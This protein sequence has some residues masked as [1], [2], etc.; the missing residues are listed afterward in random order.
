MP[1]LVN[2]TGIAILSAVTFAWVNIV[3][4]HLL[5]KR[6]PG[7]RAFMLSLGIIH[8]IYGLLL[9]YLFPLPEGLGALLVL[10]AVVSGALRTVAATIMIYC[11]KKEE[12]SRVIPVV[13]TY[14]IFVA[15]IA[16]LFLGE[17]LGYLQWLA[18]IIVVVGAVILSIR[19][20]PFGSTVW[21]GRSFLL[22]FGSS[23]FFALSDVTSKY[24]LAYISSWNMFSL[25]AFCISGSFLLVS[26][27]PQVLRQLSNLER[28]NWTLALIA[29]NETLAP[30]AS[31][32][33]FLALQSGPVS[34]VSTIVSSRPIF[35]VIFALI[36]SRFLP[37]FL[38][39]Q[40]GKGML[41][42]RLMATVMIVGG[43]AIIY[44]S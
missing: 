40:P 1:I 8:L 4:G 39:W 12:V 10:V 41:A 3:D 9:F 37:G 31:I 6:L 43:I 30:V 33:L 32:L 20:S 27:R 22:L 34:L 16:V 38:V 15:T 44:L 18:I 13:F 19:Q 7:L 2:W 28:R 42:L 26:L 5:S 17:T 21:L 25:T 29:F 24:A 14:P 35:V 36:L 11:L 23:L